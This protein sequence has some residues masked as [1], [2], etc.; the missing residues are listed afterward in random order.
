MLRYIHLYILVLLGL[1]GC[2]GIIFNHYASRY[3]QPLDGTYGND[4]FDPNDVNYT[5][6]NLEYLK[7]RKT[8]NNVIYYASAR[9][10][11]Q[12][13]YEIAK[14]YIGNYQ[15]YL[16]VDSKALEDEMKK[17]HLG[18]KGEEILNKMELGE[19]PV[20]PLRGNIE[21]MQKLYD[22]DNK[23]AFPDYM[24]EYLDIYAN[25]AEKKNIKQLE[26]DND[27]MYAF[28]DINVYDRDSYVKKY[29]GWSDDY[30][31][32]HKIEYEEESLNK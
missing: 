14:E 21:A 19:L 30:N 5:Q 10:Y 12:L 28:A 1:S 25:G 23:I 11:N 27:P 29:L 6:G 13:N 4:R 31:G 22:E 7:D 3:S 17:E 8:R 9:K 32:L 26:G 24:S 16:K 2:N 18:V 20:H 15:K